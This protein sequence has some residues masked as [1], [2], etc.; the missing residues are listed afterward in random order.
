MRVRTFCS[1]L[2]CALLLALPAFTQGNPTGKLS[3]RVTSE[4]PAAPRRDA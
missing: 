3:G 4:Q 1:A 2:G